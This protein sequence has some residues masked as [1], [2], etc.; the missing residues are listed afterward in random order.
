MTRRLWIGLAAITLLLAAAVG[1]VAALLASESGLDWLVQRAIAHAP[2]EL[3]VRAAHGRLRGPLVL[4]GIHY[5][6]PD[7]EF[8]LEHVE[9]DWQPWR[10]LKNEFHIA[11]L[12]LRQVDYTVL[13]PNVTADEIKLPDIVLPVEVVVEQLHIEALQ[14][15]GNPARPPLL[16]DSVMVQ[17]AI[18]DRVVEIAHLEAESALFSVQAEGRMQIWGKYPVNLTARW[19]VRP[20]QRAA[21]EGQGWIRGDLQRVTTQQELSAPV[22]AKV[23]ASV[24]DLLKLPRWELSASAQGLEI[25]RIDARAAFAPLDIEFAAHGDGTQVQVSGKL[26]SLHPATGE[27]ELQWQGSVTDTQVAIENLEARLLNSD[28]RVQLNGSVDLDSQAAYGVANINASGH[29]QSLRWP[30]RDAPAVLSPTGDFSLSGTPENYTFALAAPLR[31]D[32]IA[33]SEWSIHGQG[34]AQQ[35]K[36]TSVDVITL[37][38]EVRGTAVVKWE[39]GLQWQAHLSG[40][41]LDPGVHWSTWPG[42]LAF[43]LSSTGSAAKDGHLRASTELTKLS[44]QLRGYPLRAQAQLALNGDVYEL[45]GAELQSD[46]NVLRVRGTLAKNWQLDWDVNA[47]KLA[48][49]LP[50]LQG[51]LSARGQVRGPRDVPQ[52]SYTLQGEQL[53]YDTTQ[54]ARIE[55][56]G[57][58]DLNA[59][60]PTRLTL[61]AQKIVLAAAPIDSVVLELDGS[62]NAHRLTATLRAP[63]GGADI[64]LA[65]Q[66]RDQ[67]W[68]GQLERADLRQ[69]SYG[70]WKLEGPA[71]VRAGSAAA[72]VA[73]LCLGSEGGSLCAGGQW[74]KEA[75]VDG[76]AKLTNLPVAALHALLPEGVTGTGVVNGTLQVH[77]KPRAQQ[78]MAMNGT[79]QLQI[80]AGRLIL[81]N[82]TDEVLEFEHR[83]ADLRLV[84][85]A[86]GAR[87]DAKADFAQLG[88]ASMHLQLLNWQPGT[89]PAQQAISGRVQA[90]AKDLGFLAGFVPA[91]EEVH[92]VLHADAQV[93]G[94]L[95]QPRYE[96]GVSLRNGAAGLPQ[97]GIRLQDINIDA[98]S[99]GDENI[100][101]NGAVRS[102]PGK[103]EVQGK[104]ALNRAAGWPLTVEIKGKDFEAV[105]LPE[106]W[107]LASPELQ[108][109]KAG[110]RLDLNGVLQIPEARY[111]ARDVS[112]T[113][114]PS[115]DVVLVGK[116]EKP[117]ND[118]KLQI[119]TTVRFSFGDKVSFKGFGLK[120]LV[121]GE[122]VAL[123]EPKKLT[124]GYG[125]LQVAEA[126]FN[127][128]KVDLRV[129]RGRLV[130]AGGPINNPG[131]D[132]RAVRDMGAQRPAD[133]KAE[134]TDLREP[135]TIVAGVLV[136]GTLR[137]LQL[138]L[139][140]DPPRDQAE[141]L[142]LLLFGVPLGDATS[143]QGKA[144]FLAASSLRLTGRDETLRKIGQKFGLEEI[145]LEGGSTP[146]QAS[147]VIGRYLGPRLYV[148]YS[149]GL[150]TNTNNVLRIRYRLS[151][152]WLI[153][154]EQSDGAESAADLLY[155]FEH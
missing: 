52:L 11:R 67:T 17:A 21:L 7:A 79:L 49:L 89:A 90:D 91:I 119:Y 141:M 108:I 35:I 128:Y 15:R 134:T 72:Q 122:V 74:A 121:R 61:Q 64:A 14:L 66:W 154:S 133:G 130:F 48:A 70:N 126:S 145:R 93:R 114:T 63:K 120:G 6:T 16:I 55:S 1:G 107:V 153:Q 151:K 3:S 47:P 5:R 36:L 115:P 85:D 152:K 118:E 137:N 51:V 59:L 71:A 62:L 142:S 103:I 147:L 109:Y 149:V 41:R 31:S 97:Q 117:R 38:G 2:G 84:A 104:V 68:A 20:P 92:G 50:Q 98:R 4:E 39:G 127:A 100:E 45:R 42:Q 82:V 40:V 140:S 13:Q 75:G 136:R 80:T 34:D 139:F 112:S 81:T 148:N 96:G 86:Q 94:T 9:L 54:V 27:F 53:R 124:T 24:S 99:S 69:A 26:R 111:T 101:F 58:L 73:E 102:G 116:E 155:M 30:L 88:T 125:E 76:Q 83:G 131:I 135:D 138:T 56:R 123:D 132:A 144:L 78:A 95:A 129:T 143:E 32:R 60:Q 57:E 23:Q 65:G 25:N 146:D 29:W 18:A 28:T 37:D 12:T 44:G 10:L 22:T 113:Q 105:N 87:V 110:N 106:A 150:F 19:S 43:E 46:S 33:N 8:K 77:A